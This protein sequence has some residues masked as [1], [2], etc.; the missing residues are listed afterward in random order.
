M[1]G[2]FGVLG[3]DH[4][5]TGFAKNEQA[6]SILPK[7]LWSGGSGNCAREK[8]RVHQ[9]LGG[10]F[11]RPH[12]SRLPF[13]L[14]A[15]QNF[16]ALKVLVVT[17]GWEDSTPTLRTAARLSKKMDAELYVAYVWSL[18]PRDAPE[19]VDSTHYKTQEEDAR[20]ALGAQVRAVEAAGGIVAKTYL[21]M[22]IPEREAIELSKEVG[23]DMV[24]VSSRRL[25]FK[26][27]L[28]SGGEAERI[29]RRAP[30]SVLVVR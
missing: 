3:L 5:T 18:L 28:F 19:F 15:S 10:L 27:R 4:E 1:D 20:Q 23:A 29:A 24:I 12:R 16:S 22:G 11:N 21:R 13:E 30:C 14:Q 6:L 8:T 7:S 9:S 26:K 25:G 2:S 17:W